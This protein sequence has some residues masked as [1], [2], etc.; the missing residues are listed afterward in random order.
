MA[1]SPQSVAT[2][3]SFLEYT[4]NMSSTAEKNIDWYVLGDVDFPTTRLWRDKSRLEDIEAGLA[5]LVHVLP[6]YGI[7]SVAI[8]AL[9]SGLGGL[10]WQDVRPRIVAALSTVPDVSVIVFEPLGGGAVGRRKAP[11]IQ[12]TGVA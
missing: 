11:D 7:R 10:D 3:N 6:S 4:R 2:L 9:G 5:D 12:E 8:P 1:F